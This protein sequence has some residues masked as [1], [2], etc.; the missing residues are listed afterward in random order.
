MSSVCCILVDAIS[1]RFSVGGAM[2]QI[3][4]IKLQPIHEATGLSA[5][6]VA[7]ATGI[8]QATVR[9]YVEA[10][11]GVLSSYVPSVIVKLAEYYG[12][13]W[14]SPE[15]VEVVEGTEDPEMQTERLTA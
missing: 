9:K 13:D 3:F 7:K 6:A 12:V 10:Q 2:K 1:L 15:V 5:Y 8:A 4:K 11:D 14:R